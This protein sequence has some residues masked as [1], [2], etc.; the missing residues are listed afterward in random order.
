MS[1]EERLNLE[2]RLHEVN[3]EADKAVETFRTLNV[4]FPDNL[5]YGLRLAQD[6]SAAGHP[7]QALPILAEVRRL[8]APLG[9]DPRIDYAEAKAREYTADWNGVVAAA[10]R[11]VRGAGERGSA[12]LAADAWL[13]RAYALDS[14]GRMDEKKSAVKAAAALYSAA[15]DSNGE[16]RATNSLANISLS[17]GNVQEAERL[18]RRALS[19]FRSVGNQEGVAVALSNLNMLEWLRGQYAESRRSAESLVSIRRDLE[20][21]HGLAWAEA[22]LGEILA[23]HGDIDEAL[24]LQ[25]DAFTIS[26][27]A[28]YRDYVLYAHYALA[29]TLEIS[30]KLAEARSHIDAALALAREMSDPS[31]TASRLDERA[32]CFSNRATSKPPTGMPARHSGFRRRAGFAMRPPRRI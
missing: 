8:P 19:T 13:A 22:N 25:A 17:V 28:G 31:N 27:Q 26:Q 12:Q 10:D 21:S 9:T 11:A 20:D 4:F 29:H 6:L 2:G 14:L 1:R 16:A 3:H 15:G 30:G 5:E 24:R 23:D 7:E 18:Y 32:C